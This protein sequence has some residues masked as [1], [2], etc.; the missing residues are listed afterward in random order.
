[1]PGFRA[2][3][4]VNLHKFMLI[5]GRIVCGK[6]TERG[7]ICWYARVSLTQAQTIAERNNI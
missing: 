4:S 2:F 3:S 1:M 6:E 5:S 7:R